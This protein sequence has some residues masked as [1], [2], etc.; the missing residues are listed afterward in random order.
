MKSAI[1]I[2]GL[3][4]VSQSQAA[5]VECS[6]KISG[7]VESFKARVNEKNRLVWYSKSQLV[8]A[9]KDSYFAWL[10]D[11]MN[12][13]LEGSASFLG[14]NNYSML[15]VTNTAESVTIGLSPNLNLGFYS[16]R[17]GGSGLGNSQIPMVCRVLPKTL[18]I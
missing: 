13:G 15:S 3:L 11:M 14:K 1:W 16:Y 4:M 2:V 7:K 9:K 6:A 17:D 18:P 8:Y 12:F 10:A 5:I